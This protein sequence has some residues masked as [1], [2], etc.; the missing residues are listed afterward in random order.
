VTSEADLRRAYARLLAG[1]APVRAAGQ[2]NDA[3][4]VYALGLVLRA[5]HEEG[6]R[7]AFASSKGTPNPSPLIFRTSPGRIFSTAQDYSHATI[8]FPNGPALEAHIGVYV[9]GVS[10]IAHECDVVVLV[11]SEADFCRRNHVHPKKKRAV[12]SVEC[13]FFSNPLGIALGRQFLGVTADLGKEGRYFV[14]N[15]DGISVSR[16]LAHHKRQR[17]FRLSPL[18]R[19]SEEQLIAQFRVTFRDLRARR[20]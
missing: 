9:E 14:S 4:E 6:A 2:A 20:R 11:A 18:D 1:H 19:D 8:E 12:L 13:K 16:I 7:I 17:H 5:A 10:G 15:R 3:F